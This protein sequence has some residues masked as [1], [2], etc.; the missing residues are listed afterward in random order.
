MNQLI[1]E[2]ILIILNTLTFILFSYYLL[3]YVSAKMKFKEERPITAFRVAIIA[4]AFDFLLALQYNLVMP[5]KNFLYIPLLLLEIAWFY[6]LAKNIYNTKWKHAL[7]LAMF[8]MLLL[9]VSQIVVIIAMLAFL[10]VY[11]SL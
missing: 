1:A 2:Y 3:K 8:L 4:G 10:A 11:A 6:I 9:L 5:Q 7:S